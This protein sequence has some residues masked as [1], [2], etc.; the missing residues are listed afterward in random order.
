MHSDL[1]VSA[2][3]SDS[4][5]LICDDDRIASGA[6]AVELEKLG[7]SV[8]VT[9]STSEAFSA[10]CVHDFDALLCAPFLRDGSTIALPHALGIRRPKLAGLISKM[11]E[12]LSAAVARRV[13]FDLQLTKVVDARRLD[14]LLRASKVTLVIDGVE[15]E[16][17]APVSRVGARRL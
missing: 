1:A 16:P 12:R 4:Y 5:V 13:G 11:G 15:V 17:P 14:A 7:H 8:L 3:P 9:C 6:L 10:A 2:L